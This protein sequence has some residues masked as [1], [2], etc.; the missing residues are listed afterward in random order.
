MG[1][2]LSCVNILRSVLGKNRCQ[3]S[4]NIAV[5]SDRFKNL[6]SDNLQLSHTEKTQIKIEQYG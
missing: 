4:V 3:I 2:K 1:T 5:V 6:V